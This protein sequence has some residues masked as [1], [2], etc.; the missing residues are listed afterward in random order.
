MDGTAAL[1][2]LLE[3]AGLGP[4]EASEATDR[5]APYACLGCG[6]TYEVQYHVC[7]ECGGFSVEPRQTAV[8]SD[9]VDPEVDSDAEADANADA[10]AEA[11]AGVNVDHAAE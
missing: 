6:A 3:L 2:R 7:P 9:P 1:D 10:N 4:R 5:T 8:S 11:N